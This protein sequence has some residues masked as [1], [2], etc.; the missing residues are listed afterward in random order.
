[1]CLI[2]ALVNLKANPEFFPD[3][4]WLM[5]VSVDETVSTIQLAPNE[6]SEDWRNN[7]GSTRKLGDN[8][9][10]S[11]CSAL[12]TVPSAPSPETQNYLL[13]PSHP[14]SRGVAMNWHK[15]IGYDKRL[16]RTAEIR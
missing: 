5:N 4:F 12:L 7:Q 13:N 3:S 10:R 8:W 11:R 9:L 2:E 15:Q 16:F 6:L 1:M 14:D